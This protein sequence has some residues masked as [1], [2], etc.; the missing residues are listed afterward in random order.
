M[1]TKGALSVP[2]PSPVCPRQRGP[3]VWFVTIF[4]VIHVRVRP[5]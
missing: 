3:F 2:T 4:P 5:A 1:D